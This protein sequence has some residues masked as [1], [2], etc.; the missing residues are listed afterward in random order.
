MTKDDWEHFQIKAGRIAGYISNHLSS[1][2]K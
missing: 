2:W 1:S